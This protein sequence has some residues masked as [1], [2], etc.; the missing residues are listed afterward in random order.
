MR[1]INNI[2][3]QIRILVTAVAYRD[4]WWRYNGFQNTLSV[5]ITPLPLLSHPF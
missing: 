5:L 2:A 4:A 3:N 1:N